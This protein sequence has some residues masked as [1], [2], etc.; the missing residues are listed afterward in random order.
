MSIKSGNYVAPALQVL[1][2]GSILGNRAGRIA[3]KV[4]K[5]PSKR[6]TQ[7]LL[8]IL[9]DYQTNVKVGESFINYYDR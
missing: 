4:L 2:G 6:G 9:N 8:T 7:A 3:D 5:I 1:L